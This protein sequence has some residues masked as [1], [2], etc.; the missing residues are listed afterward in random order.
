MG[1]RIDIDI[2]RA[3][4]ISTAIWEKIFSQLQVSKAVDNEVR[5]LSR[6]CKDS[7]KR[8]NFLFFL[9]LVALQA[10]CGTYRHPPRSQALLP[11][12][13]LNLAPPS[14]I[15]RR[16]TPLYSKAHSSNS[17]QKPEGCR[18]N[19]SRGRDIFA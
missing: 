18:R 17:M 1:F 2:K 19:G 4:E 9:T 13:K 8:Q 10:S 6:G 15:P 7:D 12:L 3:P 11:S 16:T 5:G 14:T